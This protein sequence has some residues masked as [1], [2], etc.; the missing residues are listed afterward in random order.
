MKAYTIRRL[1]L[2]IPTLFIL[3]TMVFLSVRFVP[4][5]AIDSMEA[6][7]ETYTG[8]D[9]EQLERQLGLDVPILEQYIGWF[10]DMIF[11]GTLGQSLFGRW[12]VEE[13]IFARLP[14]TIELGLLSVILS[15]LIALP[16]GVFSATRQDTPAD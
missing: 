2:I 8:H 5:D 3:A 4:G 14:V 11:R 9:R 1:L 7:Y 12:T 6:K 16:V 10:G 13:K 15:L